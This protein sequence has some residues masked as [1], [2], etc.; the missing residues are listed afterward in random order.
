M[1]LSEGVKPSGW[2]MGVD[3]VAILLNSRSGLNPREI[4]GEDGGE[5]KREMSFG[6]RRG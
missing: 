2:I 6:G 1:D 4:R 3:D 5:V